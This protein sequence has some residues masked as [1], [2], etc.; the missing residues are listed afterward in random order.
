MKLTF[1]LFGCCVLLPWQ[2]ML[3]SFLY[4]DSEAFP[5]CMYGVLLSP[6]YNG[7]SVSTQ[8]AMLFLG[9]YAAAWKFALFALPL[10][11][12]L[13]VVP[14][15]GI[16]DSWGDT[17]L[18]FKVTFGA[19][20]G[21]AFTV[22]GLFQSSSSTLASRLSGA[23][24]GQL[25]EWW[26]IG[27][28][29]AGV[30]SAGVAGA[31]QF[32]VGGEAAVVAQFGTCVVLMAM[33]FVRMIVLVRQGVFLDEPMCPLAAS[34]HGSRACLAEQWGAQSPT[35]SLPEPAS[36]V[37]TRRPSVVLTVADG[38]LRARPF[39]LAMFFA[40]AETFLVFPLVVSKW[41]PPNFMTSEVFGIVS[42]AD[43][44][45]FDFIGR[46]IC[47]SRKIQGRIRVG[48]HN[49]WYLLSLR[50]LVPVAC[51]LSWQMQDNAFIGSFYTRLVLLM[52]H[53]LSQ[54]ML[55]N[56]IFAWSYSAATIGSRSIVGRAMPLSL[57]IGIVVGSAVSSM[58]VGV[59]TN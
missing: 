56:L 41:K 3:S 27:M 52:L 21:I 45:L 13:C 9:E 7:V 22:T 33:S 6:V 14:L 38:I 53:G 36:P 42:V 39:L 2:C 55:T 25:A 11:T 34:P 40:Y 28:G 51:I 43:V 48:T 31:I 46:L 57:C 10:A 49:I 20:L 35:L 23:Q 58:L 19:I 32:T 18:R 59:L 1:A 4:L 5:K 30:F 44:Q 37:L 50:L 24:H 29:F 15:L 17:Q 26:S 8:I 16:N 54:G 47:T 12:L